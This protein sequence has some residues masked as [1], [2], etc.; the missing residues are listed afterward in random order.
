MEKRVG[1]NLN[2]YSLELKPACQRHLHAH[3]PKRS[4]PPAWTIHPSLCPA[5]SD[6]YSVS[7]ILGLVLIVDNYGYLYRTSCLCFLSAGPKTV[8]ATVP[9]MVRPSLKATKPSEI[10]RCFTTNGLLTLTYS[11]ILSINIRKQQTNPNS[12]IL[13]KI[14]N[15]APSQLLRTR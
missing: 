3:I 10:K 14:S 2:D 9:A 4:C 13:C 8:R 15:W 6:S 12:G 5:E 7:E 1:R 11:H